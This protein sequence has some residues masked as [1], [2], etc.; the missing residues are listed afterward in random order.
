[1]KY[2]LLKTE[3][4][5]FSLDDLKRRG[6]TP[7]DGVRNYQARNY[8][9]DAMK[10]GDRVFI[11]HTGEEKA[12][13]GEGKVCS[14]PYSDPT[15]FDKKSPYYDAKATPAA[16]LWTLV[17]ICFVKRLFSSVSLYE[18]RRNPRLKNMVLLRRGMRLSIQMV[19]QKEYEEVLAM[20]KKLVK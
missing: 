16:P 1:M 15:Q 13:V 19:S 17:D 12:V 11:Y 7:W 3:P 10:V 9:R 14:H 2:W 20:G 6:K 18:M 5:T 4:E 8:M